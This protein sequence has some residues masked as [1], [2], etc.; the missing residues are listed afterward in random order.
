MFQH[1][2]SNAAQPKAYSEV[3]DFCRGE[4]FGKHVSNHVSC[5]TVDQLERP[6]FNDLLNE[7]IVDVNVFGLGVVLM[8]LCESNRRLIVRKEH[9]GTLN[10]GEDIAQETA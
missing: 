5:G 3:L 1:S 2:P 7:M 10:R 6:F 9:C 4:C 8:V